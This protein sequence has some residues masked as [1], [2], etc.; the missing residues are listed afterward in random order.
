MLVREQIPLP[1]LLEHLLEEGFGNVSIEQ[2]L[3][4]LGEHGHIP[5]DVIHVQ[6]NEPAEQQVV[7][8]LFHQHRFAAHRVQRLQ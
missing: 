4:V 7:V 8:E 5:N 3:A 6:A 2:T 1:R